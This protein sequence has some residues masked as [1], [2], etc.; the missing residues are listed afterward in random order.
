ML[1]FAILIQRDLDL[2]G[3]IRGALIVSLAEFYDIFFLVAYRY[4]EFRSRGLRNIF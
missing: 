3:Q 2:F 1:L 4:S